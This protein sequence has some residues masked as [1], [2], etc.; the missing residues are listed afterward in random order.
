LKIGEER[1]I[2]SHKKGTREGKED[3]KTAK[4][5]SQ[6]YMESLRWHSIVNQSL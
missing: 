5:G 4:R 2:K 6:K 3:N 1:R